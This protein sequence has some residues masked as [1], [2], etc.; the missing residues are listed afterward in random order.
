MK[1][2]NTFVIV[3]D[4]DLPDDKAYLKMAESTKCALSA[5]IGVSGRV[6]AC[7]ASEDMAFQPNYKIKEA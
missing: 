7:D 3:L 1:N 4:Q 2:L 5:Y 6:V